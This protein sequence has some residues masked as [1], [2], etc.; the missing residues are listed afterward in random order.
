MDS[1]AWWEK[2]T[3]R[4]GE[5]KVVLLDQRFTNDTPMIGTMANGG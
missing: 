5:G 3:K 4:K 1:G 2:D